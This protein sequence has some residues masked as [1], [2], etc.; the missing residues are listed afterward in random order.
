MR[1]CATRRSGTGGLRLA[2][3]L[4]AALGVAGI[5]KGGW[6]HAKARLGQALIARAWQRSE[7]GG[8]PLRPWPWADTGPVA[9]LQVPE[10]GVDVFVLN[11]GTGRTLAWGPGH[12]AGTALP[13]GPGNAVVGGHRDTHFAFLRDLSIGSEILAEDRAGHRRRYRVVRRFVTD[14]HDARVLAQDGDVDR[15]TLVT[16]WPFDALEVGGPDRFVVIAEDADLA[17]RRGPL[18][19]PGL[20]VPGDRK[21][22]VPAGHV[23]EDQPR[24][25]SVA[26]GDAAHV[27][28][29]AWGDGPLAG[30]TAPPF[31][32]S[33][34]AS[35]LPARGS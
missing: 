5:A 22:H 25:R 9:R 28:E 10:L 23:A 21:M 33:G 20:A 3:V 27:V 31:V 30:A 24:A 7:P 19:G 16:C 29:G 4:I 14:E 2:A 11:G 12:L 6:I 13:G 18:L 26:G 17:P 1:G 8:A 32:R 15:L 35:P 34:H